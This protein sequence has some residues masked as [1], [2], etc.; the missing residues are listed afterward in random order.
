MVKVRVE[1]YTQISRKCNVLD[2]TIAFL[3]NFQDIF[4][5]EWPQCT[6]I[7]IYHN[8]F[9]VDNDRK[10][11]E[12]AQTA[13]CEIRHFRPMLNSLMRLVVNCSALAC[14]TPVH[15]ALTVALGLAPYLSP[16][17]LPLE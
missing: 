13:R 15:A 3:L 16:N 10:P 14:Q 8:F 7:V 6:E 17:R 1:I 5:Q 4:D 12:H 11:S 2:L 9:F